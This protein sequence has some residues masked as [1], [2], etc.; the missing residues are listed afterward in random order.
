M[1]FFS[2]LKDRLRN[3]FGGKKPT[4]PRLTA[5]APRGMAIGSTKNPDLTS[6]LERSEAGHAEIPVDEVQDFLTGGQPLF[7]HSTNVAMAQYFP[8]DQKMMIEYKNGAAYLY[9]S[10]SESDAKSFAYA[11][12]KGSWVWSTLRSRGSKTAH[13]RPYVRLR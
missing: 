11:P 1:A 3:L 6:F 9:S 8:E 7:V 2:K 13:K 5:P 10:I 4:A 12:S